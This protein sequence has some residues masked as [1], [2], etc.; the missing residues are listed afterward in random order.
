MKKL[1]SAIVGCGSIAQ[2]HAKVLSSLDESEFIACADTDKAKASALAN[3][4]G[5]NQYHSL[6]E[7]LD[8]EKID[9]LH[10][11]TPHYLH[12]PMAFQA[13]DKN[14]AVFT[15]KPPAMNMEQ[16]V[17][18]STLKSR[19]PVGICFQNRYNP[20]V[21]YI[22][23]LVTSGEAGNI[24]GARAIVTW[25][26]GKK[27]Y[28]SGEWRGKLATEGGGVLINQSIHTLDL[29]TYLSGKP[30][31][32]EA[33][34]SNHHLKD[35][36]EVED[37]VEAFLSYKDHSALFYASTAYS[38]DSKVMLELDCSK[39]ILTLNGSSV[40]REDKSGR[41][42]N[43]E[44]KEDAPLG[45][46]Y[47]GNGHYICIKDYYRSLITGSKPAI[48]IDEADAT[49]RTMFAI[50]RSSGTSSIADVK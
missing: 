44:F 32:V 1:R 41:I 18:F 13:A 10:I 50:Y 30:E 28:A 24:N 14:I 15:E 31:K 2:V 42:M 48:S 25:S 8:H 34:C 11:C 46:S 33:N 36:I 38:S 49:M 35:T 43:I 9:V 19:I 29:L 12:T 45:K 6:E 17:K 47:W 26:R 3:E 16:W 23:E 37:T 27:Y 22:H 39:M 4:Y 21:Q 5:I 7:M 20:S 40:R